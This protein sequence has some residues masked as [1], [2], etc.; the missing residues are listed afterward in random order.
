[1]SSAAAAVTID[2][3]KATEKAR[4]TELPESGGLKVAYLSRPV[5]NLATEARSTA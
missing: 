4:E 5:G 3:A 2:L 1:M